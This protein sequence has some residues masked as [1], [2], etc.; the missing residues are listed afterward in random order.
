MLPGVNGYSMISGFMLKDAQ[1]QGNTTSL[2]P[3][4]GFYQ[5]K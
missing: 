3:E 5:F 4:M 1:V 2:T